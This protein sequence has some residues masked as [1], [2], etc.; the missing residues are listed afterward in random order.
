M[1]NGR[2][3]KVLRGGGVEEGIFCL[4]SKRK[5]KRVREG[6]GGFCLRGVEEE[7]EGTEDA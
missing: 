1:R 3:V 4:K 7:E 6:G 2:C 5:S